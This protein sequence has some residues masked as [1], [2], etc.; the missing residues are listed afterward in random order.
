MLMPLNT[1]S[2]MPL[3]GV[4]VCPLNTYSTYRSNKPLTLGYKLYTV[5]KYLKYPNALKTL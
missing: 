5:L 3:P 1:D 2:I 4:M